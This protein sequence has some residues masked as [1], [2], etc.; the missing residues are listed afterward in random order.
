MRK[1]MMEILV[2]PVDKGM[3]TLKI[4]KEDKDDVIDGSLTCGTCNEVYPIK[5]SIPNLLPPDLR[6]A[7]EAGQTS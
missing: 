3:L 1:D 4:D 7:M 6:R 5:D 2:C